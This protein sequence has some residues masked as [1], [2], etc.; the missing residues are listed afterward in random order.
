MKYLYLLTEDDND[1][2]FFHLCIE[3]L[4]STQAIVF[5]YSDF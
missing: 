3:Q 5:R 4:I 2:A 1:D